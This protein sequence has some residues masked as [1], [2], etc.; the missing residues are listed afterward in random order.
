MSQLGR[1]LDARLMGVDHRLQR[2]VNNHGGDDGN[3][4]ESEK[5]A[6]EYYRYPALDGGVS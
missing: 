6:E 4:T 3:T 2:L 1:T 5:E